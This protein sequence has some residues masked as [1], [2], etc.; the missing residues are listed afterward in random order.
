MELYPF[1]ADALKRC[2]GRNKVAFYFDMGLG[3]TFVGAEKMKRLGKQLNL[4]VCQKSKVQD[5][6]EH[7]EQ[8]YREVK[9]FD[10][11]KR[12]SVAEFLFF[13]SMKKYKMS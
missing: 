3:K 11:T 9:I 5:W 7:F 8:Y 4:V 12:N 6:I 10:L 2:K 1:Q 13:G